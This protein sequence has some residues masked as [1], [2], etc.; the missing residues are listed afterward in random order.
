MMTPEDEITALND[1]DYVIERIGNF[2][3]DLRTTLTP[4]SHDGG[5]PGGVD[6]LD[7]I[8]NTLAFLGETITNRRTAL[9]GTPGTIDHLRRKIG[10]ALGGRTAMRYLDQAERKAMLTDIDAYDGGEDI[11]AYT[12]HVN[13]VFNGVKDD[14]GWC[15]TAY[16]VLYDETGIIGTWEETTWQA[17]QGTAS[18]SPGWDEPYYALRNL[19][20]TFKCSC[21]SYYDPNRAP[22]NE[23]A[24][25]ELIE[26][27]VN[28]MEGN[29]VEVDLSAIIP[30][31]E[32]ITLERTTTIER[33]EP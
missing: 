22:C 28:G 12:R 24:V 4:L 32:P 14:N 11:D 26:T 25:R 8:T 7:T 33:Y 1:A 30:G 29:T 6:Q 10:I 3:E 23:V 27:A 18:T 20:D 2:M 19:N 31:V 17:R 5:M 9:M 16:A 13:D 21:H 15:D